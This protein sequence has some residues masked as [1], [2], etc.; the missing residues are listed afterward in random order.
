MST[1]EATS[2]FFHHA[3]DR[4]GL[5]DEVREVLAGSYRELSVQVKARMDDDKVVV[6]HGYRIQHNGARGPYKGGVRFHPSVDLDEVRALAALMTWKNAL[7][8]VPFGGAKGGVQCDPNS[9]SQSE[10][11]TVTRRFMSM[12]A[13]IIGVNRDIPAPDMGTNAQTMAWMM[14][15]YGQQHGHTPGIVTGKPVE[16]GGSPGRD[17]ATGRG[18]V[19]CTAEAAQ[20][21]GTSLDGATVVVQGYG[22]VGYWT[23]VL[24]AER[25]AKVVAVSD[26][27][28]GVLNS[29]GLDLTRLTEHYRESGS[30]TTY[31]EADQVS[32]EELLELDCDILIPAAIQGVIDSRNASNIKAKL[33]VEAANAPTTPAADDVLKD[34]GI[35]VIPDILANAGGVTVSYFEWV[36]NI[37][38]FRW[39]LDQVNEELEKK[40]TEATAQVFTRAEQDN[41]S[42][43]EA[44]FDIAVQRVAHADEL[45]GYV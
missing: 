40:M 30:L 23:A 39:E 45:R 21:A 15:A 28:G 11:Q 26:A 29:Q 36:Q 3:A 18:V 5:R 8:D 20:R 24:A 2:Y 22:N 32:N 37:Q 42:L 1:F 38:Q 16:L 44:A 10:L 13:Y 34:K 25:G 12:I 19:I 35:T 6:F 14:D 41:T 43:R 27:S 17:Q 9:L 4:V 31:S 33:I 7:V